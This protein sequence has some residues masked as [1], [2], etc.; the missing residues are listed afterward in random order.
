MTLSITLSPAAEAKLREL[1]V[2]LLAGTKQRP[3][4][5]LQMYVCD[6]DGHVIELCSP[7]KGR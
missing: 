4:G 2:P 3:D 5:I 6:P 7:A 1:N